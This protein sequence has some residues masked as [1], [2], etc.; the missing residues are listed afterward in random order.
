[1]KRKNKTSWSFPWG[2]L[3]VISIVIAL[4]FSY[5][6]FG[7]Q[8][9]PSWFYDGFTYSIVAFV[10]FFLGWWAASG[11]DRYDDAIKNSRH[12]MQKYY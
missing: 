11:S 12:S 2:W 8:H 9:T 3:A 7:S 1:M 6:I 10:I 4:A 5:G